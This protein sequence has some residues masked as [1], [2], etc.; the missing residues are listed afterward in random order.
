MVDFRNE[1]LEMLLSQSGKFVDIHS[2]I[3]KHCGADTTFEPD[4]QTLISCRLNINLILR[5]LKEMGWILIQPEWGIS[6]SHMLNQQTGRRYFTHA[7]QVKA[8]LTTKGEIEYKNM[9]K[10]D[11]QK[12]SITGDVIGSMVGSQSFESARLNP[13]IE[14]TNKIPPVKPPKRSVLEIIVWIT[15]IIASLIA[16]WE[17]VFKKLL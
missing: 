17:F 7:M 11:G 1:L 9:K 6:S 12:I 13:I 15:G 2:L 3:V 8:R 4:D 5:E 10:K 14:T 16:I